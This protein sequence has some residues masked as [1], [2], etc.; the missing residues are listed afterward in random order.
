MLTRAARSA[1]W[2]TD[3]TRSCRTSDRRRFRLWTVPD[4]ATGFLAV[5][6]FCDVPATAGP[7]GASLPPCAPSLRQVRT[8]I[9][10]ATGD[11]GYGGDNGGAAMHLAIVLLYSDP[12]ARPSLDVDRLLRSL[13]STGGGRFW[14]EMW[15]VRELQYNVL[16]HCDV[17][18]HTRLTAEQAA[19]QLP[20][21]IRPDQLLLMLTKDP[22]ARAMHL[23]AGDVVRIDRV[24][25]R[26]GAST[27]YRWVQETARHP[28]PTP[29]P[30]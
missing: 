8:A 24:D 14:V 4:P 30:L 19:V 2:I 1:G 5:A 26:F 6:L 7:A 9:K 27:A 11:A 25:A 20:R 22:V 21:T 15:H 17:P 29:P 23:V 13:A 10:Q 12:S 3:G 28:M 16:A 18:R